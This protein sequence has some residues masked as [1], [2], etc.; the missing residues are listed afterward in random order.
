MDEFLDYLWTFTTALSVGGLLAALS[1]LLLI[2]WRWTVLAQD[3]ARPQP[4]SRRLFHD[5]TILLG[6]GLIGGGVVVSVVIFTLRIM[7]PSGP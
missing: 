7:L 6:V 3:L 4:N 1:G 2:A 5:P